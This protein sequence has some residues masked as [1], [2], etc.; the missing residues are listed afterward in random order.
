MTRVYAGQS[1]AV[2]AD[3]RRR[4]LLDA[5]IVCIGTRGLAGT[6]VRSVCEEAGLSTRFFYESF[7]TLDALAM[8]AYDD[9]VASAFT[10]IYEATVAAGPD[11]SAVARAAITAMVDYIDTEPARART[12]LVEAL[13]TGPLAARRRDTMHLIASTVTA[14]GRDAYDLERT[15]APLIR[16]GATLVAGGVIELMIGW[17]D[18]TLDIPRA[19]VIDDCARLVEAIGDAATGLADGAA[20]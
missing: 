18:G 16:I 10:T 6:T 7:A 15:D 20:P 1:A 13:A 2:R 17:L 8:A 4:R 5:A 19:R 14:I 9:C 11:R 3:A 12:V